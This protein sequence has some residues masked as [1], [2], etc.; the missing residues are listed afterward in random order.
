MVHP[1]DRL[2]LAE[3]LRPEALTVSV[4]PPFQ[5][6]FEQ[7]LSRAP[8]PVFPRARQLYLSKYPLEPDPSSAFRTFLFEEEIQEAAGGA[9][10][11]RAVAFALVHWHG[12]QLDLAPYAAYLAERWQLHPHDLTPMADA[13]WFRDGGAWARFTAPAVYERAAPTT[14]L[15]SPAHPGAAADDPVP[16]P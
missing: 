4:H 8:G 7:L 6:A 10:R 12:P 11:I 15:S 1:F 3:A 2:P 9:V 14:L 16:R 13:A 5:Q